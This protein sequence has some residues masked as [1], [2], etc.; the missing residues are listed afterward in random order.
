MNAVICTLVVMSL[1]PSKQVSRHVIEAEGVIVK[2]RG[3]RFYVDFGKAL[4]AMK[5]DP[6]LNVE[7]RWLNSNNCMFYGQ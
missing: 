4:R 6:E 5:A 3:D 1:N 7:V 2:E